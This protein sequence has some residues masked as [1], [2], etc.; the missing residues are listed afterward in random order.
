MTIAVII[1]L[2]VLLIFAPLIGDAIVRWEERR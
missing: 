2:G 1:V